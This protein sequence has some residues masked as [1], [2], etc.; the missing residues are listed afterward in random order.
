MLRPRILILYQIRQR[1]ISNRKPVK[2]GLSL[3]PTRRSCHTC[4]AIPPKVDGQP[5]AFR[6]RIYW[7]LNPKLVWRVSYGESL[8]PKDFSLTNY[9]GRVC[10]KSNT[11]QI[12]CAAN[13]TIWRQYSEPTFGLVVF[14]GKNRGVLM[15]SAR[16]PLITY[17]AKIWY[18][19]EIL[20]VLATRMC[21]FWLKLW[22]IVSYL[23][24]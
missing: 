17:W 12:H 18:S 4:Q 16:D 5:L 15:S 22:M 6:M 23:R 13:C 2:I 3:H 9:L 1:N 7:R 19:I 8:F 20:I 11:G 14:L 24:P 10:Q 21:Y